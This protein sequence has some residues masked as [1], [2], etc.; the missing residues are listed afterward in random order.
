MSLSDKLAIHNGYITRSKFP[1]NKCSNEEKR[2]INLTPDGILKVFN[3]QI[4]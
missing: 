1:C 2:I 3:E 4:I